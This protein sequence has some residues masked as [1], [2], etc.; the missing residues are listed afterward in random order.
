MVTKPRYTVAANGRPFVAGALALVVPQGF[1][2]AARGR[3]VTI[4]DRTGQTATITA[5]PPAVRLAPP[6][7]L[8]PPY[9]PNTSPTWLDRAADILAQL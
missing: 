7:E 3:T 9:D 2:A 1:A 6:T 5:N 8:F 4:S